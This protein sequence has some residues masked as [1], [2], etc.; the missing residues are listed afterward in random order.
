M[1]YGSEWDGFLNWDYG[2]AATRDQFPTVP[3]SVDEQVLETV[4]L[5]SGY[6]ISLPTI[7]QPVQ[8]IQAVF[9]SFPTTFYLPTITQTTTATIICLPWV[10]STVIPL[11]T[12]SQP[13]QVI[14]C[15]RRASETVIPLPRLIG[16]PLD[17]SD[18]LHKAKRYRRKQLA[19][20][21]KIAAQ[22]LRER[23]AAEGKQKRKR[24]SIDETITETLRTMVSVES[25]KDK[26]L[27]K[28]EIK[29]RK[30]KVL[31]LMSLLD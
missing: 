25:A 26:G 21:E 15:I 9:S 4:F 29:K 8:T 6:S 14:Q 12:I 20:E 11:P 2:N 22:I 28:E 30:L 5:P 7:T 19:E 17:L 3:L 13:V 27:S 1:S 16:P 10:V 18:I 31:L 24:K 23:Y